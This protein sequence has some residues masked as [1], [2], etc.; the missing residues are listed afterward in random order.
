M[1][2]ESLDGL[3]KQWTEKIYGSWNPPM[4]Y[5]TPLQYDIEFRKSN[6]DY[7]YRADQRKYKLVNSKAVPPEARH[8]C[9]FDTVLYYREA[10]D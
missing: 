3:T 4:E 7:T 2:L 8:Y 10:R 9:G 1:K 5:N 6:P